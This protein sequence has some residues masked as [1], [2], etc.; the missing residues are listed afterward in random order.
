MKQAIMV[1]VAPI[2]VATAAIALAK[3]A[4]TTDKPVPAAATSPALK[5]AYFKP[6][7]S[8]SSGSVT[9]E[10]N[11]VSYQAVAGT[12]IVHVKDWDDVTQATDAGD[13][14]ADATKADKPAEA[15]MFYVAYFRRGGDQGTRP[16]TFLFNGG[17]GSST[18]WLHMGAFGPKRVVTADDTHTA[19]APYELVDNAYTLLDTSDL[20][21]IDAP[22]TGFSRIAGKDKEKAFFGVDV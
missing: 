5:G 11:T 18:V 16:V 20:V 6:E 22:A 8:A 4:A 21:F 19:A 2:L 7:E 17:P 10:G 13:K 12:L 9:V 14:P 15:S 3:D 1:I